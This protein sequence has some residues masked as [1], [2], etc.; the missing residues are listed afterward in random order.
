M[1]G[2]G[3]APRKEPWLAPTQA[4]P[5]PLGPHAALLCRLLRSGGFRWQPGSPEPGHSGEADEP[6]GDLPSVHDGRVGLVP[7][8]PPPGTAPGSV[9]VPLVHPNP[10]AGGKGGEQQADKAGR[11]PAPRGVP[12]WWQGHLGSVGPL[13]ESA[14]MCN[15]EQVR[16]T[17]RRQP[18]AEAV[19]PAADRASGIELGTCLP[20]GVGGVG[21][22]P[23]PHQP[24]GWAGGRESRTRTLEKEGASGEQGRA[25][26]RPCGPAVELDLACSRVRCWRQALVCVLPGPVAAAGQGGHQPSPV[27]SPLPGR[28]GQQPS[29][30]LCP[31]LSPGGSTFLKSHC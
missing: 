31:H 7:H 26:A 9:L 4:A 13:T 12:V 6:S 2:G 30:W 22:R 25:G 19:G 10:K 18:A 15:E 16:V 1:A 27:L 21:C 5:C 11:T 17:Q 23:R 29:R 20:A 8:P 28:L 14:E 3:S 24:P